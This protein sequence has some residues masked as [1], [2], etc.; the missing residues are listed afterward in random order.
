MR[1]FLSIGVWMAT[2]SLI[3]AAEEFVYDGSWNTTNRKLDGAMT[4][5]A[6]PLGQQEWSC[7]FFGTWQGA[8]F[9]YTVSF[10]GP[11]DDLR[12]TALVD[13]ANYDF[14]ARVTRRRF[15]SQICGRSL[16]GLVRSQKKT[17]PRGSEPAGSQRCAEIR[18]SST[19]HMCPL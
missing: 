12:G 9:D 4:C 16:H 8:S 13:G 5:V 2:A 1:V 7:H 3:S 14:R 15:P 10:L 17:Q 18:A 11:W 6:T 19:A